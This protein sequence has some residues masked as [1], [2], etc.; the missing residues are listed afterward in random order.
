MNI[1]LINHYA[2]SPSLG[3][4]YRPYHF[5][6]QW[7]KLG[8]EVTIVA[9]TH[10]HL[11]PRPSGARGLCTEEVVEGVQYLWLGSVP[12][13]RN[14]PRRGI[15]ILSFVGNALAHSRR[16]G[17]QA[18]PDLVIASSTY[19]LDIVVAR[20]IARAHKARLVFEV[21]D[22][23]P[24]TPILLGQMSERHPFIRL[25]QW[26]EDHAYRHADAVVSML[27]CAKEH[28][29]GRGMTPGKY[30]HVPNGVDV[31]A[32]DSEESTIPISHSEA[33]ERLRGERRF[34][35]TYAG[36]HGIA[37]A[38]DQFIEA[39]GHSRDLPITFVLVGD[40]PLKANLQEKAEEAGLENVLF[41]PP[42]PK[43]SIP[44]L[45]SSS[46]ALFIGWNRS[47]LYRHGVSPNK[48]FEYMM[49]ARPVVHA[50]EA[51]NDP[52]AEAGCGLTIPPGEPVE[53]ARAFRELLTTPPTARAEMGRRGRQFVE[54]HHDYRV[55]ARQFLEFVTVDAG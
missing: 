13:Q 2:G 35:V 53:L 29:V 8:H 10:S 26:A 11:R 46:D 18:R 16:I 17:H 14:G 27:P 48:L 5:A 4:E 12:Y 22:L 23:W 37:N 33:L 1:L 21:H 36:H 25:L 55:L 6:R 34:I 38:L 51:G 54:T 49:A 31:D 3:M 28:M 9:A 52:V 41:L 42:L 19:P 20:R 50:I 32:W 7:V 40:G 43:K 47:P 30:H 45:L 39:A 15:N 24:L 44:S